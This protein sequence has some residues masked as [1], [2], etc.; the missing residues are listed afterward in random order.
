MSSVK[1]RLIEAYLTCFGLG[2]APIAS[3]TFGTLGGVALAIAFA[4]FWPASYTLLC[5]ASVVVFT[6]VGAPLGKWAEKK[7]QRKDPGQYVL[8]EV[9]GFLVTVAFIDP[10]QHLV[11]NLLVGF[12]LFR[13]F[14][15][16]KPPPARQLEKVPGGWGIILDDIVAGLYG[17]AAMTIYINYIS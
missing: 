11:T 6:L 4:N 7:W 8:D 5:L 14:D 12:F 13:F 15:I 17:A 10:T 3:G 9:I 2:Y 16:F 1:D